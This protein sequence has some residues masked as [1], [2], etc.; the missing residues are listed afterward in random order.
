MFGNMKDRVA[1]PLC[2]YAVT[3]VWCS[4][5]PSRLVIDDVESVINIFPTKALALATVALAIVHWAFALR[6]RVVVGVAGLWAAATTW[7]VTMFLV[8]RWLTP[9]TDSVVRLVYI[10]TVA[11][12]ACALCILAW[13]LVR[14][15]RLAVDAHW[16][17]RGLVVLGIAGLA[18]NYAALALRAAGVLEQPSGLSESAGVIAGLTV[19]LWTNS[20]ILLL[21]SVIHALRRVSGPSRAQPKV[22]GPP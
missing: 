22:S 2:I 15:R 17:A 14:R 1:V 8:Y 19:D 6:G 9:F 5:T 11:G 21:G 20:A 10:V 7:M 18:F 3:A 13:H 4:L 16:I 12:A